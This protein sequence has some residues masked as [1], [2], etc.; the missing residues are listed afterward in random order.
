V[1][2]RSAQSKNGRLHNHHVVSGGDING[3]THPAQPLRRAQ[4]PRCEPLRES[5]AFTLRSAVTVTVPAEAVGLRTKRL[6]HHRVMSGNVWDGC[7]PVRRSYH[8]RYS[9]IRSLGALAGEQHVT[10]N[11]YAYQV[12][13]YRACLKHCIHSQY[14]CGGGGHR[15]P[16]SKRC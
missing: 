15:K 9:R 11:R 7:K 2:A 13:D 1:S 4:K 10:E 16:G 12:W 14:T 5:P 8:G 3:L 6:S